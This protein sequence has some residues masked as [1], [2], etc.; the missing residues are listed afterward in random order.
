MAD[1]WDAEDAVDVPIVDKWADEDAEDPVAD[2]WDAEP[3]EA[4]VASAPKQPTGP[5]ISERKR[6]KMAEEEKK[7]KEAEV[8][9]MRESIN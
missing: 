3:E 5:V 4:P 2:E 9:L 1:D 6:K 7:R 8:S